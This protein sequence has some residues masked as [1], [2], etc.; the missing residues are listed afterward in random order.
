MDYFLRVASID[1]NFLAA[2]TMKCT[3]FWA[4]LRLWSSRSVM[5]LL[6]LFILF[7]TANIGQFCIV[8]GG[9]REREKGRA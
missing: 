9:W 1:S 4:Y 2:L 8:L 3:Y 5:E 7:H 6:R